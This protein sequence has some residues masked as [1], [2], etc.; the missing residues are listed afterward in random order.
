MMPERQLTTPVALIIFNR[1]E[2]TKIV[3]QIIRNARPAKLFVIADGPRSDKQDEVELCASA[4]EIIEHI[5]WPCEVLKNYS[6]VNLGSR[7]RVTS[8]LDWVFANVDEAIILEDD[9]LPHP[10]FFAFCQE[11]LE[12]YRSDERVALI[13]GDD[14]PGIAEGGEESYRFTIYPSTWGW[15]TWRRVW[16]NYDADMIAWSGEEE[17]VWL[18]ERLG[19]ET[20]ARYWKRAFEAA[21]R[22]QLDAWDLQMVYACWKQGQLSIVPSVNLISNIGGGEGATHTINSAHPRLGRPLASLPKKLVHPLVIA[23]DRN[24]DRKGALRLAK[25]ERYSP[26][27]L[28]KFAGFIYDI[29]YH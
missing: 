23:P 18:T 24:F 22:G 10:T 27:L 4:R 5:D 3:F 7:R 15:A 16:R 25:I 28:S 29:F 26:K 20:M 8:G 6:P 1:P 9:C 13:R 17:L 14:W 12:R 21:L 2:T 11:L 19:T